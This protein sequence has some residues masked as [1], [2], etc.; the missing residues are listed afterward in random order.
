MKS[1]HKIALIVISSAIVLGGALALFRKKKGKSKF[2]RK[3]VA[4][5]KKEYKDWD[6][7]KLKETSSTAYDKIK[8]YW[9][10]IGWS[11]SKWT[12]SSVAWS[13][14]F[15][16]YVMREAKAND[17]FK[18]SSSHSSY[19]VQA[20]KNRKENNKNPFKAYL[21]EEK[22]VEVGDLICYPRQSNVDY[23]TTNRYKS[24]CD[25]V[26]SVNKDKADVIGGNVGNTVGKKTVTLKKGKLSDSQKDWF[27]IIKTK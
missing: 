10:S 22:K 9:D 15:I 3:I 1:E 13:S 2:R 19:I 23:D 14:A 6:D 4:I 7:G 18:Y 24:H 27:T 17:D 25:I 21:L 12:P 26:V 20:I 11:E 16:S 8:K 5:A